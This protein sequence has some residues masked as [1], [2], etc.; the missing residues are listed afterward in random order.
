MNN[1]TRYFV[2][3]SLLVLVVGVGTGL[4]AYY[5]GLTGFA[6]GP[7]DAADLRLIPAEASLVGYANVR[8]VMASE[9][10]QKVR[11]FI[12]MSGQGQKEIAERTGINV[13]TDIEEVLSCLVP[14]RSADGGR[15]GGL[16]LA[17]GNFDVTRLERLLESK[18]AQL[19]TYNGVRLFIAPEH[20]PPA[21]SNPSITPLQP[22]SF[23][24][25][26]IEPAF[27]AF[28]TTSLVKRAI[29]QRGA[30]SGTGVTANAELMD[31][32]HSV[33]GG[34]IWAVGDFAALTSQT[35]LPADLS[36]RLP[37]LTWFS[38]TANIDGGIRGTLRG[39]TR[40]EAAAENLRQV[41]Q[42]VI[43]FGRLQASSM[44]QFKPAIDSLTLSG[45]GKTVSVTFNIPGDMIDAIGALASPH[46][47][48]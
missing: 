16:V 34:D 29:D 45:A 37:P 17:R 24:V 48:H 2:I 39:D 36:G 6:A 28:G 44:P 7:V 46:V 35:V 8:H 30:G 43:A 26:F 21:S 9:L 1:R 11:Q 41:I 31:L 4:V 3:A 12:P 40:D 47:Q 27:A 32:V 18:G 23:A 10:R 13:D 42:G 19:E 25:S 20:T 22:E 5:A 38:A 33:D 14:A 15:P